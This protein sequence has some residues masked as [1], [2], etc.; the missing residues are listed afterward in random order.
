LRGWERDGSMRPVSILVGNNGVFLDFELDRGVDGANTGYAFPDMLVETVKLSKAGKRDEA[1]DL[2]DAHL[3]LLRYDQ[4]PGIGLAVRKYVLQR[5]GV[6]ATAVMR[7]PAP[8][9]TPETR[10]DVDYLLA[11]L[12]RRDRRAMKMAAE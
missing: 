10:A 7:K 5:R 1:H 6:L 4:Q 3:P 12:A 2:F 9:F 11:R 8:V